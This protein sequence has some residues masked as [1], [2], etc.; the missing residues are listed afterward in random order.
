MNCNATYNKS[1]KLGKCKGED[2]LLYEK[3]KSNPCPSRTKS[4][5]VT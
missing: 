1:G 4:K 5:E 2:C 3:G